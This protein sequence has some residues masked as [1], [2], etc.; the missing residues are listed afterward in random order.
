[1]QILFQLIVRNVPG[2]NVRFELNI[3]RRNFLKTTETTF[4]SIDGRRNLI[5][6]IEGHR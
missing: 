4:Q 6:P 5:P 1:M 2:R 3:L